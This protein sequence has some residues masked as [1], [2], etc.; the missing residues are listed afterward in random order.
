MAD[1]VGGVGGSG[2]GAGGIGSQNGSSR[3]DSATGAG[4]A[5][6]SGVSAA[7]AAENEARSKAAA[8]AGLTSQVAQPSALD[9]LAATPSPLDTL[10]ATPS[11]VETLAA[12]PSIPVADVPAA[13]PAP[14]QPPAAPVEESFVCSLPAMGFSLGASAYAVFGGGASIGFSYDPATGN[15]SLEGTA[16]VGVGYGMSGK[17]GPKDGVERG[18]GNS[19]ANEGNEPGM[20]VGV[21]VSANGQ[22]GKLGV[23]AET[24]IA[25]T[26]MNDAF[27]DRS[28]VST[29]VTGTGLGANA[30]IYAG[31]SVT[32]K[33]YDP[34]CAVPMS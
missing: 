7:A 29:S 26:Q 23:R 34:G 15:A 18:L 9:A 6:A 5:A 19:Q 27:A 24:E 22:V 32:G 2:G 28:K 10:A 16:E 11:P 33:V 12:Q 20:D 13:A 1:G 25:G 8:E 30:N 4:A 17:F 31:A 14:A 21:G 3:S